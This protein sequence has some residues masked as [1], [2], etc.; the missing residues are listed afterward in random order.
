MEQQRG[1]TPG[2]RVPGERRQFLAGAAAIAGGA[3]VGEAVGLKRPAAASPRQAGTPAHDTRVLATPESRFRDLVDYPFTPHYV[4][5]DAGDGARTRL[6]VHH[7]DQRPSDPA[8]ASGETILLLHGNPSWSYLYRHVIPPLVAAG[9]R[10]VAPDLVGFGKSDKPADRFLYTYQRHVDWLRATVFD[11]LDLR[12][13]T[14]VC[15]DWGGLLGLRLLAEHPDRFRRVVATNTALHTGDEERGPAWRFLAQILQA[16]QRMNPF[17]PA[18]IVRSNTLTELPPAVLDAYNAPFPDGSYV[19]GA[20]RFFLLIPI[21]DDD[22]AS[23]ANR[24][25]WTVLRTLSTPF[26]CA[27]SDRDPTTDDEP[28]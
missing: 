5:I 20:R 26:L 23:Q 3:V 14:L 16:S 28:L 6:R 19:Q 13:V 17:E 27:F 15:Q 8:T 12:D 7:V 1:N 22:G 9:H 4:W 10:C 18:T 11:Q 21:S 24:D 2:A 25:A